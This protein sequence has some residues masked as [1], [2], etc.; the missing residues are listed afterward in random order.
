M[1]S[2]DGAFPHVLQAEP[3]RLVKP[4]QK[5][6]LPTSSQ[7]RRMLS[8]KRSACPRSNQYTLKAILQSPD[9]RPDGLG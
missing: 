1:P 2:F 6:Q 3:A 5:R 8:R 4:L 9:L 7:R